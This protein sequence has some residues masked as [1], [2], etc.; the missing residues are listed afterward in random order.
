MEYT[1]YLGRGPEAKQIINVCE[2]RIQLISQRRK[3]I[4]AE[5]GVDAFASCDGGG[6]IVGATFAC[7]VPKW[8]KLDSQIAEGGYCYVGRENTKMGKAFNKAIHAEDAN[9]SL[10][11]FIL[12]KTGMNRLVINGRK[13]FRSR[14]GYYKN[15]ILIC[16]P[17][18]KAT[19][20]SHT[21]D[22]RPVPP[23]WLKEV[24]ESAFLAAQGK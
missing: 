23:A 9:F 8:A 21:Y 4:A 3:E 24:K 12:E 13:I 1:Y 5:F 11:K 22:P 19:A 7:E 2:H 14:A 10:H 15:T 6:I 18:E 16:V 20:A 17:Q